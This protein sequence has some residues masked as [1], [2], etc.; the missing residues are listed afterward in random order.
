[1]KKSLQCLRRTLLNLCI[2]QALFVPHLLKLVFFRFSSERRG[3]AFL[4]RTLCRRRWST[5]VKQAALPVTSARPLTRETIAPAVQRPLIGIIGR[6]NVGKSTIF[7]RLCGR[8]KALV[9]AVA[10]TTR[11]R[12]YGRLEWLGQTMDLVDTGGMYQDKEDFFSSDVMEQAAMAAEEAQLVIMVVDGRELLT[13]KDRRI[14]RV[15]QRSLNRKPVVLA[16]N[17]IDSDAMLEATRE[18]MHQRFR[19][20]GLGEPFYVSA[21]HAEGTTELTQHIVRE[22][23][24]GDNALVDRRSERIKQKELSKAKYAL[25]KT[26]LD[27]DKEVSEA[28]A[29]LPMRIACVGVPNVGKS[30]LVNR[31]LGPNELRSMT[32]P[33]A[34]TTHDTVDTPLRWRGEHDLILLDTAGI[35]RRA[36]SA[37]ASLERSAVLFAIKTVQSADVNILVLDSVRGVTAQDK[38]I[39]GYILDSKSSILVVVNKS[40]LLID[41]KASTYRTYEEE[42]R[43]HLKFLPWVPILFTSAT[44]G[45][46]VASVIDR[47][48][49]V[50]QMR[51]QR[52]PTRKLWEVLQ[53][54]LVRRPPPSKG[55]KRLKIGFVTQAKAGTPSFV[56]FCN[57]PELVHFSF[58]R[59]LE[60]AIRE[61]WPF[62]G[63]PIQLIWKKKEQPTIL[64][65]AP[66]NARFVRHRAGGGG[67]TGPSRTGP[68]RRR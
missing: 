38:R 37:R 33:V 58:E 2:I 16:V 47:A 64:R 45:I 51:R 43:K 31:I 60:A 8:N 39:A 29:A 25:R 55:S 48:I 52:I 57:D 32:S 67:P 17:K 1:M 65:P 44:E 19:N 6:P 26:E 50:N 42:V 21:L 3:R 18:L 68:N 41:Q 54:A 12:L 40:D 35:D 53:R 14:A 10:G 5:S 61:V 56:L 49:L 20:L 46:N 15:L 28:R 13:D 24:P 7:N 4:M 62:E 11:D 9:S 59:F 34:G 23:F 66:K 63:S 27:G 36:K 22:L 30:S